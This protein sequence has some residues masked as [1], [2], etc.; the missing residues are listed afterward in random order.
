M[1]YNTPSWYYQCPKIGSY[2]NDKAKNQ[3][4]QNHKLTG[5]DYNQNNSKCV[6]EYSTASSTNYQDLAL[7]ELEIQGFS[8][9]VLGEIVTGEATIDSDKTTKKLK[10][11][12]AREFTLPRQEDLPL[13]LF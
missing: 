2:S 6:E 9:K 10:F 13:P 3:I 7:L 4:G 12:M 1:M 8:I 11:A 5:T